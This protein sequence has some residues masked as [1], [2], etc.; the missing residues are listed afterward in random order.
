MK[1]LSNVVL[2]FL[3][4][5]IFP[6]LAFSTEK[7]SPQVIPPKMSIKVKKERFLYLVKPVVEEVFLELSQQFNEISEAIKNGTKK[8]KIALLKKKYEVLTNKELLMALK[9]HPKSIAL[10]QAALESGWG[11]S[12]FFTKANNIFGT[13]SFEEN[14]PRIAAN[15]KRKGK[16]IWVKKYS[17]LKE[18]V[19]DY[20]LTLA[21]RKLF[22][23]F[24]TLRMQTN[25]PYQL[26][27]KLDNYSE[28]GAKYGK[29]LTSLIK[30]N[31][32]YK[33]DK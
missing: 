3:I 31:H 33:Y 4:F 32:F 8:E 20:Y 24:R 11:T 17:S 10:G 27:K 28:Q 29:E 25:D 9:P 14:E 6:T 1:F 15:I 2:I 13:W 22:K 26:V 23:G 30:Y 18:S 16:T 12:R 21:S 5:S 19:R 7:Y